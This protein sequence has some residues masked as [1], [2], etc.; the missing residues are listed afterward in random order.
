[1]YG[2]YLADDCPSTP[3]SMAS[4]PEILATHFIKDAENTERQCLQV[5]NKAHRSHI[6]Y[7]VCTFEIC[8]FV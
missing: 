5:G 1:M 6:P 8:F 2:W 7:I 3:V 4:N